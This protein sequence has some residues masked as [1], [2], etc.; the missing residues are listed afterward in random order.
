MID[1]ILL[2]ILVVVGIH[3]LRKGF[4]ASVVHFVGFFAAL[5]LMMRYAPILQSL[6]L[7][8]FDLNP[9]ASAIIGYVTIF[10]SV[11][12]LTRIAIILLDKILD[13]LTL[14]FLN[15]LLGFLLGLSVGF[16]MLC[17]LYIVLWATP[18]QD[19]LLELE[20]GSRI[21][22]AVS[23]FSREVRQ[24]IGGHLPSLPETDTYTRIL[25]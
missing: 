20:S 6:L 21:L 18:L 22:Q 11:I 25:L 17:I 5:I 8:H 14:Q 7:K 23:V 1:I 15:R 12:I 4:I 13:L 3:G 16:F 10:L 2:I 9:L 24:I 19:F